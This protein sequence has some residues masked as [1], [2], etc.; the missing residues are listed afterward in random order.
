VEVEEDGVRDDVI[1]EDLVESVRSLANGAGEI[2]TQGFRALLDELGVPARYYG[3]VKAELRHLDLTLVEGEDRS[4]GSAAAETALDRAAKHGLLTAG[5]E[6]AL[7]QR[8]EAGLLAMEALDGGG[9][10]VDAV[11]ELR[12]R[13]EDGSRAA[14]E[15]MLANV[16]LVLH[17]AYRTQRQAQPA[18]LEFEDL[19]Q[20]GFLGLYRATQ[21][22]D[23]RLG[24]KFSTYAT[25]WVRQAF[26][27]G[28]CDKDGTIRLPV[29]MHEELSRL[30]RA[31]RQCELDGADVTDE[32]LAD[33]LQTWPERIAYLRSVERLRRVTSL[34][35]PL[36]DDGS[37][38]L[39]EVLPPYEDRFPDPALTLDDV[40][41]SQRLH[42]MI[43]V[44]PERERAI[45]TRRF[46]LDGAPGETLEDIGR[47]F[48]LTG[49]RIRQLEARALNR[50]RHPAVLRRFFGGDELAELVPRQGL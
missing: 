48:G 15:L 1:F 26:G 24:Y 20:E 3:A 34:D 4:S 43:E 12:R 17:F 22:F 10:P 41:L 18:G 46:G 6:V 2:A 25:W 42:E 28:I 37:T 7:A 27:R 21:K 35:R 36:G 5:E 9:I 13:T 8:I 33:R 39:W 32:E 44:L 19:V 23:W 29:H 47:S 49:E 16:R 11:P 31:R 38:S 14:Q 30:N 50:L 40:D 45:L